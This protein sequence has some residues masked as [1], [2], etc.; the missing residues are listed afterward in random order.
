V[1][2]ARPRLIGYRLREVKLSGAE[3]LIRRMLWSVYDPEEDTTVLGFGHEFHVLM[4]V[5]GVP[6]WKTL[7]KPERVKGLL[8][9]SRREWK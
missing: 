8:A 2:P 5:E 4:V 3:Y 1:K 6:I 9:E 7:A